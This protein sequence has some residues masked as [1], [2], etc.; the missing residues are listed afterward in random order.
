MAK[1]QKSLSY[2]EKLIKKNS[3]K[4]SYSTINNPFH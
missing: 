2:L 4:N 3:S 1:K